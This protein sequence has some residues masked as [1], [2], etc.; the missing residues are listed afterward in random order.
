[1]RR[2]VSITL[3][4]CCLG[5]LGARADEK[6]PPSPGSIEG[7]FAYRY[8]GGAFGRCKAIDAKEAAA[9]KTGWRCEAGG[10]VNGAPGSAVRCTRGDRGVVALEKLAD[11]KTDREEE[12]ANGE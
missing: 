4:F 9:L 11:C 2:M 8:K 10:R 1:M 12:M 7:W 3:L 6:A 5:A